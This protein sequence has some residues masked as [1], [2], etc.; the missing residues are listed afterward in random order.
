MGVRDEQQ[1]QARQ[2]IPF[3]NDNRKNDNTGAAND[4]ISPS[5]RFLPSYETGLDE[6]EELGGASGVPVEDAGG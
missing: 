4:G 1:L 3:G 2:Q 6:G 5:Q